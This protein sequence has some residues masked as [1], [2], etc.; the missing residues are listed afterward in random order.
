MET[1]GRGRPRGAKTKTQSRRNAS[2][3]WTKRVFGE[4]NVADGDEDEDL[5]GISGYMDQHTVSVN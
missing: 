2:D 4:D 3:A 5:R 1:R